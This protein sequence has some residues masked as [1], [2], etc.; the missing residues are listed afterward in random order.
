MYKFKGKSPRECCMESELNSEN[1]GKAV[2]VQWIFTVAKAIFPI[3]K[4]VILNSFQ[5]VLMEMK[6]KNLL[7]SVTVLRTIFV[8]RYDN[9]FS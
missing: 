7:V 6:Q 4:L 1:R 8:Q 2:L 3:T 9:F 5:H